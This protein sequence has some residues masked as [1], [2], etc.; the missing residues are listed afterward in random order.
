MSGRCALTEHQ[1]ARFLC[2]PS[3]KAEKA[4]RSEASFALP[5]VRLHVLCARRADAAQALPD[6]ARKPRLRLG[7]TT[8]Q[9]AGAREG[10]APRTRAH[11]R[12]KAEAH[13]RVPSR[14][15]PRP[16]AETW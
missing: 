1:Q 12:A 8:F 9:P 16:G 13:G 5:S 4:S 11:P 10:G 15:S 2:F 7:A 6:A 14:A 3:S